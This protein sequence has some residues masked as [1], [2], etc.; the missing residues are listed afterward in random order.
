MI[1]ARVQDDVFRRT[2]SFLGH[3]LAK[4]GIRPGRAKTSAIVNFSHPENATEVRRF[5]G[6]S[7]Y[8][9]KFIP[10]YSV[11]SE[12]LRQLLRKD[13]V[14]GWSDLQQKAFQELKAAL[15]S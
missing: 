14:F 8:F 2:I 12:P 4:D 5:L 9:R 1:R 7:G 11:I 13:E 10:A 15:I 6:L 3:Q